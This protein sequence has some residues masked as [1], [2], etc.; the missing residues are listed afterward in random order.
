MDKLYAVVQ[1]KDDGQMFI[2]LILNNRKEYLIGEVSDDTISK[3][4]FKKNYILIKEFNVK[5][6][7]NK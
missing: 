4:F 7:I 5:D 2:A 3:K 1:D 6:I